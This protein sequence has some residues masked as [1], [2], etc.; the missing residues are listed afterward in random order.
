MKP[1]ASGASTPMRRARSAIARAIGCSERVSTAAHLFD[2]HPEYQ[3]NLVLLSDGAD[4]VSSAGEAQ[5]VAAITG[6]RAALFAVAISSPDFKPAALQGLVNG[7]AGTL[8]ERRAAGTR[9][10]PG[11]ECTGETP[12]LRSA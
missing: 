7:A 6:P 4:T 8:L 11:L 12:A 1:V 10:A 5:A 2:K 3:A 9:S